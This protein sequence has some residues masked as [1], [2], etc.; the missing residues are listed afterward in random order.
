MDAYSA[1]ILSIIA[2][3]GLILLGV[4]IAYA[5]GLVGLIGLAILRGWD[6]G[7]GLAGFLA[8]SESSHYT[9]SVLPMFILIGYLAFYAGLTQGAF[10]AARCWLGWLPGGL[11]VATIFATA[12]FAAVSGA[13]TATAAVFSR[14]AIPEMLRY[15]YDR[16]MAAAVVAA[17]GT[18]ASLIPPS[19]I[20]VIYGIIVEQSI[21]A[22]LLAGFIPG[23]L[24][25]FCYS[26]IIVLRVMINPALGP[27]IEGVSWGE[28]FRSLQGAYGIVFVIGVILFGIYTGVMTPT[29]VGGVG[30]FIIFI[31]ALAKREMSWR[32]LYDALMETSK[33]SVM[34]FTIIWSILIYVRFL[35]FTGLPGAFADYIAHIEV[36]RL[37]ILLLIL[38]V[39]II[40]GMFMDGIGMLLLTLPVV[41]PAIVAL[42]YDPIWFGIIVVKM[43][44]IGLITPPI[45]LNCFVVNGVRPDIP[46]SAVFKGVWPFVVADLICVGLLIAF[47]Q[48]VLYLPQLMMQNVAG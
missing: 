26:S 18:L 12:G 41:F 31:M 22:L 35:G 14:V 8:H 1:G 25:A 5:S 4:R 32:N 23:A 29:E 21:G 20:L 11:A 10:Y 13:S 33:L 48:I 9:L 44:E 40:L 6:P 17:G 37:V 39:Y 27:S 38:F 3:V 19:A 28:R 43:V 30:A 42:G 15:G 36:P 34:I 47:P 7:T 16:S 45:G 2:L 46:L 24:T